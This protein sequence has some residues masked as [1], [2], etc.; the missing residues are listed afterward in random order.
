V[1]EWGRLS[2]EAGDRG[3]GAIE[4]RVAVCSGGAARNA[5]CKV[6]SAR[7]NHG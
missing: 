4:Q 5:A 3:R 2:L 7:L 6:G 1:P